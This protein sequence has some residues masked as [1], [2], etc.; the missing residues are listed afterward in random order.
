M[1]INDVLK[2]DPTNA[3]QADLLHRCF[4]FNMSTVDFWLNYCVL[5]SETQQYPKRM[6]ANS[7]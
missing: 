6:T 4:A 3:Q 1:A 2:L 5:P 7:W